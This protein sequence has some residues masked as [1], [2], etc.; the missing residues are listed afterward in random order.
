METGWAGGSGPAQRRGELPPLKN[1]REQGRRPGWGSGGG[2]RCYL[3]PAKS[4]A[5][6]ASGTEDGPCARCH[7]MKTQVVSARSLNMH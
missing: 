3:P 4:R 6:E 7:R 1:R 5:T 2:G